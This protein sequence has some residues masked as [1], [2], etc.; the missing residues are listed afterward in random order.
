MWTWASSSRI[1][2]SISA[3]MVQRGFGT[4]LVDEADHILIDEAATPLIISRKKDNP[5]LQQAVRMAADWAAR[6]VPDQD[7]R[8]RHQ[9]RDVELL[10]SGEAKIR[11]WAQQELPKGILRQEV[12]RLDWV[13]QALVATYFF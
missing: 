11:S 7:F 2:E 1:G 5:L 4:V 13:R 10:P 6:L 3:R 8:L 9:F 12:W